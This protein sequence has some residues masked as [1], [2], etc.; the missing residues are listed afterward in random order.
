MVTRF[1]CWCAASKLGLLG[2]WRLYIGGLKEIIMVDIKQIIE[3]SKKY[4][5]AFDKKNKRF[6]DWKNVAYPIVNSTVQK[7]KNELVEQNAFFKNNLYVKGN[8]VSGICFWSGKI[9]APLS[10]PPTEE[11]FEIHF[12]PIS[13]GKINVFV[14]G[15]KIDDH[16]DSY[17]IGLIEEPSMITEEIVMEYVLKGIEAVQKTSYLFIGDE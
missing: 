1:S 7:I 4:S 15:H 12:A 9:M 3:I 2:G 11:G 13:N 14:V 10:D 16:A 6:Q 5:E 17:S 8:E